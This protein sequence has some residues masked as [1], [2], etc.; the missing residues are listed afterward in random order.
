[1]ALGAVAC[2]GMIAGTSGLLEER[3][4]GDIEGRFFIRAY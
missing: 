4:V 1:V 2:M 3:F